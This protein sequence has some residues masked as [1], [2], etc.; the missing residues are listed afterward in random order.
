MAKDAANG[1]MAVPAK[2]AG[3][4]PRRNLLWFGAVAGIILVGVVL[5]VALLGGDG[6]S[7]PDTGSSADTAPDF[8]FTLY[9][10][11]GQLGAEKLN[12]LDLQGTPVVVNFWA[13]LCP[14]CRAEMPDLQE[15][16]E[17]FK[18]RVTLVG[19][20]L[21]QFT[22]LGSPQDAQ[23]LLT[24]L[25]VTYPAGFTSDSG[26][27]SRYQVLSMPTTVFINSKGEIFKKWSGALNG[28]VLAK[29]TEEML[30]QESAG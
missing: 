11:Q 2:D 29:V 20:D 24:S 10:G 25:A 19:V 4:K 23:E 22:G 12:L 17:E 27:I 15:F 5:A 16:H 21:G 7:A 1:E 26:V 18:D 30:D 13:G 14:P 6:T 8:S 9:Q 28:D 3:G